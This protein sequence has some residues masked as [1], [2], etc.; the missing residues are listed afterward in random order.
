MDGSLPGSSVHGD[1]PG[2]NPGVGLPCPSPG[3]LSNP[4]IEP[5]SPTFEADSLPSE[6]SGKPYVRGSSLYFSSVQFSCSV[7]SDSLQPHELQHTRPPCPSPT[8]GVH[9]D[10]CP[11]SSDAIQPSHPL[12]SRSPPAPSPS[13]HQ[14]L[15]Q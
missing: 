13:H 7:V 11:S 12:S 3:D 14:S 9:L 8:P 5:R 1:S 2:K 6:P 4:G 10:S 15:F